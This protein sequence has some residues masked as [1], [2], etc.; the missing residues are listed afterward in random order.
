MN[1]DDSKQEEPGNPEG[2]DAAEGLDNVVNLAGGAEDG[3]AAEG[4]NPQSEPATPEEKI[5]ALEAE[6]A[7]GRDQLLRQLAET[8]NVRRRAKRERE[9]TIR[10]GASA[11]ARDL[12]NVADNLQRALQSVPTEAREADETIKNL[13][14]GVELTEK[15]L[16]TALQKQGVEKIVP[17]GEK[18]SYDRHQAM[19]EV[20]GTDKPAGTVV[21]VMQPGYVMHD[22]L[23][24]PAMVGV[25]KGDPGSPP[26]D[27]N[28]VD[29]TA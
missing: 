20:P 18:F 1:D 26:D 3:G 17:L 13:V 8:E 7:A 29:T 9:E 22:R 21:E 15:E 23:L 27:V 25:A 11:L 10:Y 4:A 12:L 24:R 14:I 28:H 6:L 19:F 2:A 5:A 16:L